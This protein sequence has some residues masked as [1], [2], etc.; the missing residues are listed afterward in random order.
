MTVIAKPTREWYATALANGY[1][2][3]A[4][5]QLNFDAAMNSTQNNFHA[6]HNAEVQL[7]I[8]RDHVV[9]L[10]TQHAKDYLPSTIDELTKI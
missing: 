2:R 3:V 5:Y 4:E 7:R 1:A 8:Q 6:I 9:M 10:Q